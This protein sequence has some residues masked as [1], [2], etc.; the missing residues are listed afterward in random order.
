MTALSRLPDWRI[1][2]EDAI[3]DIKAKPFDWKSHDCVIG[4]AGR[5]VL[6]ITGVDLTAQY[7]GSFENATSAARLV[8]ELGFSSV[9]DLV[10]S[11]LPEIHPSHA[12][13]GDIAAI[14]MDGPFGHA[15]GVVNGERVFV[16]GEHGF[17]TVDLLDAQRAFK[18]G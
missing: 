2:V 6:E 13:M 8:R 18:V 12:V 7:A 11:R 14:A 10:A 15:L 1:R 9:G 4:L 17:G 3:T 5:I 16:L